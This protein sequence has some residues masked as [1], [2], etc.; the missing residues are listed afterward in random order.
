MHRIL[1]VP[2][3]RLKKSRIPGYRATGAIDSNSII[4][5][6]IISSFLLPSSDPSLN[7]VFKLGK[8]LH[9]TMYPLNNALPSQDFRINYSNDF[10][11]DP[12]QTVTM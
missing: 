5:E 3:I 7:L 8:S 4:E 11:L 6:N 12:K 2:D 9:F 10:L 1:I